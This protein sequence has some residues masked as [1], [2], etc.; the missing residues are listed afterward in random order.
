MSEIIDKDNSADEWECPFCKYGGAYI[1][2]ETVLKN[3]WKEILCGCL[4]C[5]E[6]YIREYKYVK[7]I[8]LIRK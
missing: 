6:M 1:I 7:T 5:N 3:D 2:E 8:K 4:E